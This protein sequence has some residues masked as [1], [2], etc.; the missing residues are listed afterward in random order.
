MTTHSVPVE[1]ACPA[2]RTYATAHGLPFPMRALALPA[3]ADRLPRDVLVHAAYDPILR[4][5]PTRLS[6]PVEEN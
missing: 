2:C 5:A 3:A 4:F 6:I 1:C